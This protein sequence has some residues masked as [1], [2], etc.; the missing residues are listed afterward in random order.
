MPD[1]DL[2]DYVAPLVRICHCGGHINPDVLDNEG[3]ISCETC[4]DY[5]NGQTGAHLPHPD[6]ID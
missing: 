2:A 5:Y 1:D 6:D 3:R 4:G